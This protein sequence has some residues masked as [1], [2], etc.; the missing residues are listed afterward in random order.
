MLSKMLSRKLEIDH[1]NEMAFEL[2]SEDGN[3]ARANIKQALGRN[4]DGYSC[5]P[6]RHQSTTPCSHLIYI[7]KDIMIAERVTTP[8]LQL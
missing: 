2:L 7:V 5:W 6:K 3:P 8:L 1:E 4:P